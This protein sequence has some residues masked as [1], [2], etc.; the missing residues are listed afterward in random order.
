[1]FSFVAKSHATLSCPQ[2]SRNQHRAMDTSRDPTI[3][4]IVATVARREHRAPLPR[5]DADD[6]E[7]DDKGGDKLHIYDNRMVGFNRPQFRYERISPVLSLGRQLL[8][9]L[10]E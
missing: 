7:R 3:A 9:A 5:S 4:T 6:A 1:L 8:Q 10:E 2:L